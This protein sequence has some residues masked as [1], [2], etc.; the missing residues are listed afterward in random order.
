MGEYLRDYDYYIT[1]NSLRDSCKYYPLELQ[2]IWLLEILLLSSYI[3]NR[4][5][6]K[7]NNKGK[8]LFYFKDL[9][10]HSKKFMSDYEL[11][12]LSTL[13]SFRNV[14]VHVGA[15]AARNYFSSLVNKNRD[16]VLRLA[17][18][19]RVDLHMRITLYDTFGVIE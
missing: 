12:A 19:A 5:S 7:V 3:A 1:I 9:V 11:D 17:E 13:I 6:C 18:L 10:R 16:A 2:F 14:Y 15:L 4:N 8:H